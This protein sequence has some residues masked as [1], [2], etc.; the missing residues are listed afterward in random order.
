[1]IVHPSDAQLNRFADGE[2]SGRQWVRTAAHLER[3]SECRNTV[4]SIRHLSRQAA[5]LAA[6]VPPADLKDR[7]LAR[8]DRGEQVILPVADPPRPHMPV[9][10]VAV[11]LAATV[12]LAV[13]ASIFRARPAVSEAGEMRISPEQYQPGQELVFE[14]H[15][16]SRFAGDDTLV[17]RAVYRTPADGNTWHED[18]PVHRVATLVRGSDGAYRGALMLP[19]DV[20]HAEFAVE[21]LEGREVDS[22]GRRYWEVLAYEDGKPSYEALMQKYH[23]LALRNDDAAL[24]TAHS[25]TRLY[26][27]K[28]GGW[29]ALSSMEL[30]L[31]GRDE[32]DK[33]ARPGHMTQFSRLERL[34]AQDDAAVGVLENMYWYARTLGDT[35]AARRWSERTLSN[36]RTDGR[37]SQM[38]VTSIL[39]EVEGFSPARALDRLED[40]WAE[41]DFSATTLPYEAFQL[42][43]ASGDAAA[44]ER[45]LDRVLSARP[46]R[47]Q[48][49]MAEM[50]SVPAGRQ[51]VVDRLKSLV[52]PG[53]PSATSRPLYRTA[54]QEERFAR[55]QR[56]VLTGILGKVLVEQGEVSEGLDYLNAAQD[57]TWDVE[58]FSQ[59]AQIHRRLGNDATAFELWARVAVDASAQRSLGDSLRAVAEE[60][61]SAGAWNELLEEARA[62]RAE[63]YLDRVS[64]MHAIPLD[65]QVQAGN[66]S[67]HS[68]HELMDRRISV[69]AFWS[70]NDYYATEEVESLSRI[71]S[72]LGEYDATLIAL[73]QEEP[74][75]DW[76]AFDAA[77]ELPFP[78]YHDV[79]AEALNAFEVW[80][81][82]VYFVVDG[83]GGVVRFS[84]SGVGELVNQVAALRFD[85]QKRAATSLVT[86]DADRPQ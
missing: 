72:S 41:G 56:N 68:L 3:C 9:R 34:L 85:A 47:I 28:P 81:S 7:I 23:D 26:P 4:G 86:E 30:L 69:V 15:A 25:I 62:F 74:T 44:I 43:Q 1:M 24:K 2:L 55:D 8:L 32:F 84:R 39:Y 6:P 77:R 49:W 27:E 42:A 35:S 60:E 73:V 11:A 78:I 65:I 14:Y 79:D 12:T 21:D 58:L 5:R 50:A 13:A 33:R 51:V 10:R 31:Y 67:W 46:S 40:L 52:G 71:A 45:W 57:S 76:L 48:R 64:S 61:L 16:T 53:S 66:S 70:R 20:V 17:V 18:L 82:P 38:R 29:Y 63:Y 59:A 37:P 19:D 22:R 75:D 54:G 36:G 83:E 80:G